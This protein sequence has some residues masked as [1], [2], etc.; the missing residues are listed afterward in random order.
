[1]TGDEPPSDSNVVTQTGPWT[2]LSCVTA[3]CTRCGKVPLDEDT[4]L[5]P[6]FTDIA[7]ARE[8]LPRDWAGPASRRLG[9][10]T[11]NCCARTARKTKRC[12][13]GRLA[14]WCL[15]PGLMPG[16]PGTGRSG[17]RARGR[18]ASGEERHMD[19]RRIAAAPIPGVACPPRPGTG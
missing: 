18:E 13:H 7:Q 5:T 16:S 2:V 1:M 19:P 4:A 3:S 8:E 6:H 11:T 15:P 10:K 17:I 14:A 9:R 12:D